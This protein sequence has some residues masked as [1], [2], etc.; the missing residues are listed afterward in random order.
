MC[1]IAE[2]LV[3]GRK[4]NEKVDNLCTPKLKSVDLMRQK[5]VS[6]VIQFFSWILSNLISKMKMEE[7]TKT[8]KNDSDIESD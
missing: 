8:V 7:S 2:R 1:S 4:I 3:F 5:I 6:A